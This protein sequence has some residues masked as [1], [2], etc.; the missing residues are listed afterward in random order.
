MK[1]G[2]SI[3]VLL[4]LLGLSIPLH[5]KIIDYIVAIV[6]DY[7]ITASELNKKLLPLREK[8]REIYKDRDLEER[9]QKA[10]KNILNKLIE[11]KILLIKA[12]EL[13]IKIKDDEVEKAIE[14]IKKTFPTPD[15]FYEELKKNEITPFEFRERIRKKMKKER[16]VRW[17]ILR[18]IFITEEEI[19][20]FYEE[21]REAYFMPDKLKISQILIGRPK[22][23]DS[24]KKIKEIFQKLEEGE[25]FYALARR[26]SEDPYAPEGGRIGFV[27]MEELHPHLRKA[28]S[29]IEVGEYTKP[30]STP[31]GYHIIKLEARR[32]P[33][34]RPL[35][36]VKEQI[37][38]R[39][40][41]LKAEKAYNEWMENAKKE[42][43]I[44]ILKRDLKK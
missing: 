39:L 43:E 15:K 44:I 22:D 20:S 36:E 42:V 23:E 8:Y 40:Y 14:E 30:I 3:C 4:F 19:K 9:L 35:E 12:E 11:E 27:F 21:N 32:L 5:S 29:L 41:H 16:L 13:K 1:I 18:G 38:G 17:E 31:T 24:E 25:N 10:R 6:N 28:L 34:Y 37:R 26:Y 33:S 2:K 7:P